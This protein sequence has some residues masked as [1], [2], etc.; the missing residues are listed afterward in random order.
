MPDTRFDIVGLGVSTVD[1]LVALDHAPRANDKQEILSRKRQCGGLTGSA[2]VAASRQGCFCG[3]AI[4]LGDGELSQFLRQGL[5]DAGVR[6]LESDILP[7]VEPYYSL[8]LIERGSGERSILWDNAK[9]RPPVIDDRLREQVLSAKCLFVD[10]VFAAAAVD[11]AAE[12]RAAGVEV[13]GD[14]ERTFD[15]SLRLM[16]LTNH[17]IVPLGYCRQLF[18]DGVGAEEAVSRLAGAPGRSLACVTDGVNGA[19]YALGGAPGD[20]A[21]QEAFPVAEVVDT[22][23]CGDVFHGVYAACLVMGMA[24]PERIR[25]ASAAAAMKA[26]V[27]G[28]QAGAPTREALDAFLAGR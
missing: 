21:R 3:H 22:T 25:R 20:V 7:G 24:A 2:L 16:D 18:G 6:L 10:H 17:L 14:F 13:V 26:R 28:A 11:I 19:W 9:A 27:A 1:E 15:G 8:I 4:S 23:G 5:A 12:A